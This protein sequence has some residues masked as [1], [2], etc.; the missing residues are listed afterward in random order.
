MENTD[1][2]KKKIKIFVDK[3]DE[4]VGNI[5]KTMLQNNGYYFV[6][7]IPIEKAE[8]YINHFDEYFIFISPQHL[9]VPLNMNSIL[10]NYPTS[11]LDI[12]QRNRSF[13]NPQQN[14]NGGRWEY[15]SKICDFDLTAL[16][17]IDFIIP[18]Y[19]FDI[20]NLYPFQITT[21]KNLSD[22][23]LLLTERFN[24]QFEQSELSK[25]LISMKQIMPIDAELFR[26]I[27]KYKESRPDTFTGKLIRGLIPIYGYVKNKGDQEK[28]D[29]ESMALIIRQFQL[30]FKEFIEHDLYYFLNPYEYNKKNNFLKDIFEKRYPEYY[31][32]KIDFDLKIDVDL[33]GIIKLIET[34]EYH[35]KPKL[36]K[37]EYLELISDHVEKEQTTSQSTSLTK[38]E[39]IEQINLKEP[40]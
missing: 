36:P 3:K 40:S 34:S 17:K 6:E 13:F 20:T 21:A 25:Q 4:L 5:L 38:D 24:Y 19:L 2:Y 26:L 18:K 12:L 39:Y 27:Q 10:K 31:I 37:E 7:I 29:K 35:S 1:T 14:V 33:S 32:I 23:Y 9:P 28:T 11:Y 22:F 8:D 15:G 16:T 30:A